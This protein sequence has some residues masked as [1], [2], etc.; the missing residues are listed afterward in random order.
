MKNSLLSQCRRWVLALILTLTAISPSAAQQPVNRNASREAREVLTYLAS[1][2]GKK[3]LLGYNVYPHT[4]DL[5]EQTGRHG[6]LWEVD[7]SPPFADANAWAHH[8]LDYRYLLSHHWHWYFDGESAWKSERIHQVDVGA[9][10]TPGTREYGIAI[11]EMSAMADKLQVLRDAGVPVLFRPLHEIDGGWFWWTD[12]ANPANTAALWRMMYDYFT[13]VRQLNNLIWVYSAGMADS[14]DVSYRARFYPG[15]AFVDIAGIDLYG[16]DY[17]NAI[18]AYR[19][20][21]DLMK[22]VAP[23]KMLA[24]TEVDGC[25]DPDKMAAGVTPAWLYCM[26]WWGTPYPS[27]PVDWALRETRNDFML[28]LERLPYLGT[29]AILPSVGIMQP[30]DD[31]SGRFNNDIPVIQAYATSRSSRIA[32]VEFLA[33]GVTVG[34]RSVP[35][36]TFVWSNAPPGLYSMQARA[37]DLTGAAMLSNTVHITSGVAALAYKQPVVTSSGTGGQSAVDG[38]LYTSWISDVN[39]PTPDDQWIYVDLGRIFTINQ[40]HSVW[41]W[42]IHPSDYSIDIATDQPNNAASWT[43]VKRV[44]DS[45]YVTWKKTLRDAFKTVPARYVRYHMTKRAGGQTWG[46]YDLL[47]MEVPSI[48]AS[49]STNG[50]AAG[51][52]ASPSSNG[53]A[54]GSGVSRSPN[55]GAAGLGAGPNSNGIPPGSFQAGNHAPV[56]T[57]AASATPAVVQE[58]N[59]TLHVGATDVDRDVLTYTWSVLGG[60]SRA[61]NFSQNASMFADTTKAIFL[62]PGLYLLRAIVTDGKGALVYSDV[63]VDVRGGATHLSDDRSSQSG[64]GLGEFE[65]LSRWNWYTMRWVLQRANVGKAV[66]RVFRS[67]ADTAPVTIY[68]FVGLSDKWNETSGPV[69]QPGDLLGSVSSSGG[70]QW[71]E[72]DVSDFVAAEAQG[73]GIAT[74]ILTSNQDN[75]NTHVHSRQNPINPPQLVITPSASK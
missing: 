6:A 55:G 36:Y 9:V 72:I 53:G 35:P 45:P 19:T 21:F 16:I 65:A 20:Y 71:L 44:T 34:S 48:G 1:I 13:N 2:Y 30:L 3:S 11:R 66:L 68:A 70:G 37:V 24:L 5:Y 56:I 62:Q 57:E 73:D 32:R 33:N 50:G 47:E 15:A 58:W 52:G 49:Q 17:R 43:T 26:P 25:P 63:Q 42:K 39:H 74:I 23:G 69:V 27:H 7:L 22:K 54:P 4:P 29:G 14:S 12:P 31:G 64:N 61:V 40:V 46:G 59:T 41:G 67:S 18:G 10:V 60:Q 38:N 8:A 75:W 51:S 28:T